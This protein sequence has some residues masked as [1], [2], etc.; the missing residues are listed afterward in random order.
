MTL[1]GKLLQMETSSLE[2][3]DSFLL[4]QAEKALIAIFF[5]MPLAQHHKLIISISLENKTLNKILINK[6][7][8]TCLV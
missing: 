5:K 1:T 4:T 2:K 7:E 6:G 8:I 3:T